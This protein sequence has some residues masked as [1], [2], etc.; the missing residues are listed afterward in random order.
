MVPFRHARTL[1]AVAGLFTA[2]LISCGREVTAPRDATTHAALRSGLLAFDPQLETAIPVGELRHAALT[3]V[4]FE[5]VRIT[6][7]RDDGTIALDTV[8]NFPAGADELTLTLTVPL[9][10][11]APPAGVPMSLRMNYVTAAGDTVFRGSQ[12]LTVVPATAGSAPPPPVQIPVQYT[13]PG[14]T[15]VGVRISP[16]GFVANAGSTVQFT[17]VAVDAAGATIAGTPIV[18]SSADP[19]IATVN[20]VSGLVTV[21]TQRGST[22]ITAQTLTGQSASATLTVT[23][24]ASRL[25]LQ[26]GDGQIGT[27]GTTLPTPIT[28][29]VQASD[30]A[31]VGGVTV[32]FAAA[33]G[34]TVTPAS[35][36]SAS[37]GSVSTQWKLGTTA[38]AQ[39]M[40]VTS[41]GLT[42]SPITVTANAQPLVASKLVVVTGP[43]SGKAGTALGA[44]TVQAQDNVGNNVTTFT[45]DVSVA[46][47]T[48]P[49]TATLGGTTTVKAVA[50]LA[51]FSDLTINHAGTGY[52]L[53]FS[54]STMSPVA[55]GA[56]NIATGD[57]AKL[58]FG[59]TPSSVDAGIVIAPA[60]TV[61]AQDAAG[62]TVPT[63]TGAIAIAIGTNPGSATLGGTLSRNAVAGVATFNDLTLNKTGLPY[64]LV[65]SATGLAG[66][67]TPGFSV[68]PGPPSRVVLVSGGGQ[69]AAAGTA[70]SPI[71]VRVQ[72]ALG[73]GIGGLNVAFAVTGGGGSLSS[74][75]VTTDATGA[76]SVVWT[77]G[78]G[79]QSMIATFGTLPALTISATST[80]ANLTWTGATSSSWTTASNWSP[81]FA[82]TASDAVTIPVTSTAP[83]IGAPVSLVSLT[84]A[85]GA[86]LT[87]N[88]TIS[89]SGSLDA[90][91]TITGSGSVILAGSTGSLKGTINQAVNVTGAS[92]TLNG[93]TNITGPL[94]ISGTGKLAIGGQTLTLT[95]NL[96]TSGGGRLSM[97]SA[98]DN[99]QVSGD[100]TFAGGIENGFLGA[101]ALSVSGNFTA[102]GATFS[103]TGSHTLTMAGTG[104]PQTLSFG[105]PIAGQGI[106]HLMFLGAATKTL[107]GV[108]Q[109][110]GNVSLAETSAP[111]D[112]S[113]S[114]R[115]GGNFSDATILPIDSGG[116]PNPLG[117]WRVA[118]TEF[119]GTNKT[120]NSVFITS[121]VTVSGTVQFNACTSCLG[122]RFVNVLATHGYAQVNGNL[123]VSGAAALL[124]LN[125]NEVDVKGNFATASGGAVDLT[126]PN[127]YLYVYGSAVFGGG[128]TAGKLTNGTLEVV[129]DFTQ[130]GAADSFAPS[131]GFLTYIG[132]YYASSA[133]RSSHARSA[134]SASAAALKA[135]AAEAARRKLSPRVETLRAERAARLAKLDRRAAAYAAHGLA[136]PMRGQEVTF[137]NG[138]V[139]LLHPAHDYSG[140]SV[141]TFANSTS[142]FFGTLY[143]AG[144]EVILA[145]DVQVAGQ[146]Q[147]G[148]SYWHDV[149]SSDATARKFTSHGADVRNLGF[150]NVSWNLLDG[151]EIGSMDYVEFDDMAPTMDQFIITRAGDDGSN[152]E[153]ATGEYELYHWAFY[154]T[155]S[156]G[157]YIKA[158]D[159]NGGPNT[160]TLY[161]DSPDPS[162]NGGHVATAGGAKIENWPAAPP[163]I[164]WTGA[165]NTSWNTAS[166]WSGGVVPTLTDDVIIPT[167]APNNPQLS[168][169]AHVH[170][171]TIEAGQHINTGCSNLYAH[172]NVV[173]RLDSAATRQCEGDALHL[174]GDGAVGGNT[175]VGRFDLLVVEANYKVSGT[176]NQVIVNYNLAVVGTGNL[177]V[178]GGRVDAHGLSTN[179]DA[180]LTMTNAADQVF[181]GAT[182]ASFNG[183]SS[184]LTAGTMTIT[185]GSLSAGSNYFAP[186]GNHTVVFAGTTVYVNFAN[187]A[188]SF[189]RN[190]QI[191]GGATMFLNSNAL[192]TGTLSRG[193][194]SGMARVAT[195]SYP[196]TA[197]M[198]TVNGLNQF[199]A[200]AM[201]FDHVLLNLTGTNAVTFNNASFVGF[202]SIEAPEAVFEV[203]RSDALLTFTSLDFSAV[204]FAADTTR[205]FV[206]NSGGAT[207]ALQS[208]TPPTGTS[209]THYITLGGPVIWP[210]NP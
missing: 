9:P 74:G 77:I 76:A 69:S 152:C 103:A 45:G 99:V 34:G 150:D 166:N 138:A 115:I 38:G 12:S 174:M 123:T 24:P 35:A 37:D 178:N 186:T 110:I 210:Y 182:G 91:T 10:P 204:G 148:E 46:I 102:T 197:Q 132:E 4:P 106:N 169:S 175:V 149:Y 129:Q 112:G 70:L 164:A 154:T 20:A 134:R 11:G 145:S 119:F 172:G 139:R 127:D 16:T 17:A 151:S 170:N 116:T 83:V 97:T 88:S 179:S 111:V 163:A 155:P 133:L 58:V 57:A 6:I 32:N 189:L 147:T 62:N 43:V 93:A 125:G 121:N 114:V 47:G 183:A 167:S 75:T 131:A 96:A 153:C 173:A 181:V 191:N 31:G 192:V 188:Q 161:M 56:F 18:F 137:N 60:V 108:P 200:D 142:S 28:A 51:T 196:S 120:I 208:P 141:I 113:V 3:Q 67:T 109:I 177:T 118:S 72:D 59:A 158:T 23:L 40:T 198:L 122:D 73:N 105:S 87:N 100:A 7:R 85:T 19:G 84:V 64:T 26:S 25:A 53:V 15:A 48:N 55:S 176:G 22:Q 90:G 30:G 79:A 52:T 2:V 68:Q 14:A 13:G 160:L 207:I 199:G 78:A 94:T 5:K 117:G 162:V 49:G 61:S 95:G 157:H 89:L 203:N 144:P 194:G 41:T 193:T 86:T 66:T 136:A 54:S 101:G 130:S 143:L 128:S 209:G 27:A 159:T 1:L 190:V 156:T 195:S 29:R 71:I 206:K 39:T 50:G 107:A 180:T 81:A 187:P 168:G 205:H 63:F 165:T 184:T 92:Y 42:G 171:L 126:D 135:P 98:S 201:Q 80:G 65:A 140:T 8:V 21:G 33:N 202:A 82:P 146:L 124:K 36:V 44:V 104:S 185:D